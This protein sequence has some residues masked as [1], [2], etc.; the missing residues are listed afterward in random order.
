MLMLIVDFIF[1]NVIFLIINEKKTKIFFIILQVLPL[2]AI[3]HL[4]TNFFHELMLLNELGTSTTN[5][6]VLLFLKELNLIQLKK[7]IRQT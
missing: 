1:C 4:I 2:M 7:M 6:V 5:L 3:L